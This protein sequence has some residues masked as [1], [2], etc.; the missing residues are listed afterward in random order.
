MLENNRLMSVT[1]DTSHS[2]MGPAT[3]NT[4]S[5]NRASYDNH[6]DTHN[7]IRSSSIR[8]S[9]NQLHTSHANPCGTPTSINPITNQLHDIVLSHN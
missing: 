3:C 1:R 2:P 5:R 8:P 6:P 9:G 4:S 7:R